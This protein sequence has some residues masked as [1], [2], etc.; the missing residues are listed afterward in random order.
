[1]K[2]RQRVQKPRVQVE[3]PEKAR[4]RDLEPY[5]GA[6]S[7][8]HKSSSPKRAG[9]G[10]WIHVQ[11]PTATYTSRKGRKGRIR[12]PKG[13]YIDVDPPLGS[14]LHLHR[15]NNPKTSVTRTW[16]LDQGPKDTS[17]SVTARNGP[18]HGRGTMSR[19]VQP[20]S[21]KEPPQKGRH[22]NVDQR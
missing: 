9:T 19:D 3:K 20:L 16:N 13:R 1:M 7:H 14:L 8:V 10:T 4:H 11:G 17:T 15:L 18:A 22:G 6:Y 12:R 2:P 21:Q 5:P